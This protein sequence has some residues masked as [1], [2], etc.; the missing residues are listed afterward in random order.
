MGWLTLACIIMQL[1]FLGPTTFACHLDRLQFPLQLDSFFLHYST[2]S[3][4]IRGLR[5]SF[6]KETLS[7][8]QLP[9]IFITQHNERVKCLLLTSD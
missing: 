2:F 5:S 7:L 8:H 4:G 9:R 1:H 6:S 3:Q